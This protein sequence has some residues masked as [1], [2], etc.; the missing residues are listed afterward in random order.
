LKVTLILVNQGGQV[1]HGPIYLVLDGLKKKI[2]LKNAI[3]VTMQQAPLGSPYLLVSSGDLAPG[4]S[5][6]VTLSFKNPAGGT[7]HFSTRVLAGPGTV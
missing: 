5:M 4:Q 3:G 6:T 2:K 7:V 1:I